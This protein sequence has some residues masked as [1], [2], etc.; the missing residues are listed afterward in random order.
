MFSRRFCEWLAAGYVFGVMPWCLIALILKY[1]YMPYSVSRYV[2]VSLG[3]VVVLRAWLGPEW[4]IKTAYSVRWLLTMDILRRDDI[5]NAFVA[6]SKRSS[7]VWSVFGANFPPAAHR[8]EKKYHP[9]SLSTGGWPLA[10]VSLFDGTPTVSAPL[11]CSALALCIFSIALLVL[12]DTTTCGVNVSPA[13]PPLRA[14]DRRKQP[15]KKR[16]TWCCTARF[17]APS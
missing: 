15:Q 11:T 3:T 1:S 7:I 16:S 9:R 2:T 14:V 5:G 13:P 4:V 12:E 10:H 17:S 8:E 6:G